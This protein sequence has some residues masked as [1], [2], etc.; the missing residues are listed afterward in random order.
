MEVLN[1]IDKKDHGKLDH[2]YF[3]FVDGGIF[4]HNL[5]ETDFVPVAAHSE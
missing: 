1:L 4:F 5:L 3:E 2:L